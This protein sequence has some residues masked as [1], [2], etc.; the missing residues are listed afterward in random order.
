MLRSAG[1]IIVFKSF[2]RSIGVERT[3]YGANEGGSIYAADGA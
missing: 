3:E 2:T 1:N